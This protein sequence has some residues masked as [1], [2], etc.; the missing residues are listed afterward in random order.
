MAR[1]RRPPRPGSLSE[2]P[3]LKI[4]SQILA[5]QALYYIF[6]FILLLFSSLVA[7]TPFSLDLV[8]GWESIR[9][10]TTQGWLCGFLAVLNGGVLMG[11]AIVALI[12]RSKLVMDFAVSL[13]FIHLLVAWFY[14]GE[15]PGHMAWWI[16]VAGGTVVGVILGTW[17]CRY[18]ELKPIS[19][20]GNS[21]NTNNNG[22]SRGPS[23][24]GELRNSNEHVRGGGDQQDDDLEQGFSRGRG[25]GR[26]RDGAGEYEM[27]DMPGEGSGSR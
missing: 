15:L 2:L 6:S 10:D 27:V 8:L 26:G 9:G 14:T 7:G 23:Q 4:A 19:F 1:R 16:S 24:P 17:G 21:S 5:L 18:R 3:P 25:R 13:H 22:H 11:A 12:G 20:G